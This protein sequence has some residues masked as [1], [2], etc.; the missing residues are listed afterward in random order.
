[1][2]DCYND[3]NALSKTGDPKDLFAFKINYNTA[4]S[5]I[6]DVKPLY[7]GNIAETYWA[8]NSDNGIIR[9]YGYKYDNLNRLKEGI[10]KKGTV[11][12]AYDETLTYDKNGNIAKLTRN[13]NSETTQQIDNL[14]YD[15]ANNNNSNTLMKVT[16]SAPAAYKGY[17]FTDSAANTVDDYSYDANGNM[18][19]DNNKNITS[20]TY[21]Q[22][23]LPAK[24][25][26]AA[27][28]NIAY[29]YN[30]AGEKVQKIVNETGKAA[31]TTDYLGGYQYDNAVLKFFPTAEGYVEPVSGSYKYVYQYK[32]H[33]GNVRLSYDKTLAIKEES[34]YYPFGLKQEGY[35]NVKIGVENKYKY[36][37]KELQDELGLNVYD[38]G[39]RNYD[40]A[41]GRM[42]NPDPLA[43]LA[44]DLTPNRYCFNN[45]IR[46]IDPSG[47]WETTAGGYTTNKAEDIK[48]Y[49]SYL[50]FENN[51]LN[52]SPTFAQQSTFI[53]GEMS[54]GGQ[55]KLSDGSTLADE[56]S[57]TTYKQEGGGIMGYE[58]EKS[59]GNFWHGV[60]KNL[61]PNGL[62]TR[63]IGQN[64]LGLTYPGGNNPKTYSG[65]DDFSYVPSSLAEYPAIGHDRR[66]ANIG[67]AGAG[68]LFGD[69]KAI[70]ADWRFVGQELSILTLPVDI[71][72]KV[73]AGL[74]GVGL[75]LFSAGK[76][77]I[78]L[79]S[80][81][82]G[83]LGTVLI[84][85]SVAN[86]GV[87]NQP[88]SK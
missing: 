31:I 15:Y 18:I 68:G 20:I 81:Y 79:S 43:E 87:N 28:G 10:Y 30:A 33:L 48:R 54:E 56:F 71:K 23:N 57:V 51:A 36:N 39:M 64:L 52:N 14:K 13:G 84:W 55:G 85:D 27:T 16:D 9:N 72:T 50:G 21:N 4:Q 44:Y 76:T 42:Q 83:G 35:N 69:S 82:N 60:Q 38:Y 61:T 6:T 46:F 74:L 53:E 67:T 17:G 41:I 80:P 77:I 63:T 66:Y 59:F 47:L 34:N 45:P 11:L 78:Q 58:D 40:P 49:M 19:K 25:T 8:S 32:D 1:M 88:S 7:N 5:G 3:I 12:N 26:F 75:G 86:K 24:I 37:G 70:G 2:A 62:D 29:I 22:L 73:Q 65:A